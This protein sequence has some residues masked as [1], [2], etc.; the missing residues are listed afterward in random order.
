MKNLRNMS[1]WKKK[2]RYFGQ[3]GIFE[4]ILRSDRT[5][6]LHFS[7]GMKY[8][9]GCPDRIGSGSD[10]GF[11]NDGSKSSKDILITVFK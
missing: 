6:F 5:Y 7:I 2:K 11:K 8:F 1:G 10:R 9:F 4:Y 3:I